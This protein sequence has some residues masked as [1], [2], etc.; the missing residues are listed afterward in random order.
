MDIINPTIKWV[1]ESLGMLDNIH[2]FLGGLSSMALLL[3][4]I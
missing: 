4:V 3:G 2:L 1:G